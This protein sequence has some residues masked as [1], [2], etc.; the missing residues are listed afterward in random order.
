M[1]TPAD[2]PLEQ[3]TFVQRLPTWVWI[4]GCGVV[5]CCGVLAISALVW[6]GSAMIATSRTG[7]AARAEEPTEAGSHE[8]RVCLVTDGSIDDNSFNQLTFEGVQRAADDF[9][10][11]ITYIERTAQGEREHNI[12]ACISEGYNI[13][14]TVGFV[15][16]EATQAAARQNPEVYFIGVDQFYD[17]PPD[18]LVGVLFREDEGGFLAGA[19]AAQMTETGTIA[20][21]YGMDIPPVVRFRHGYEQGARFIDPDIDALGMYIDNF[22]DPAAGE[23][24]ADQFIRDGADV[25]FGAAGETGNGGILHA[26]QQGVWVIGVDMDQYYTVFGGGDVAGAEHLLTSAVKRM[27]VGVYDMIAALV[28]GGERWMGGGH[29]ILGA[30][31]GG[32][33]FAPPHDADVPQDVTDRMND[34]L[35]GLASGEIETGVDPNT[36]ELVGD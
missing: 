1:S 12:N 8:E 5:A 7:Q 18:N 3:Q 30:S 28:H 14:V 26:A 19:M 10:L 33:D 6:A 4:A 16:T 35:A 23:A 15:M 34:I 22:T 20:G 24:A 11:D 13:I 27:D 9:D 36:G 25:I 2:I 31:D 32:I 29:Y 21:I 17:G